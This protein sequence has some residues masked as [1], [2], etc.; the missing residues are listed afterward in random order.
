MADLSE[1]ERRRRFKNRVLL[2][3]LL[4]FAVIVYAV[5]VVRMGGG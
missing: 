3:V 2:V 5:S 4:A 1:R